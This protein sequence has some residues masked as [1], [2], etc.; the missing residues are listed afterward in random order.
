MSDH[1]GWLSEA[2][3]IRLQPRLPNHVRGGPR[4]DDRRVI[5]G[6]VHISRCGWM[7][8]DAPACE[9]PPQRLD[10][11]FVRWSKA[12]VFDRLCRALAAESRQ[13]GR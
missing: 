8:R 13:R 10:N 7:W 11:R 9:G 1:H 6:I 5:S 4:A 3:F 2:Q 12:G